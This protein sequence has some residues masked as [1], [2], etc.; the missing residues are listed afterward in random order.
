MDGGLWVVD[1]HGKLV[2]L[3]LIDRDSGARLMN[4]QF[5]NGHARGWW[6]GAAVDTDGSLWLLHTGGV[7]T[8]VWRVGGVAVR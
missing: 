6:R 5:E 3:A 2:A 7:V 1:G 4:M 8:T